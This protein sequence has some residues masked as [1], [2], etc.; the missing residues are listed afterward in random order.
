MDCRKRYNSV[1]VVS[2]RQILPWPASDFDRWRAITG[3]KVVGAHYDSVYD[4]PA[5]NDNGSG[6]A[7]LLAIAEL[8][9]QKKCRRTLRFVAFTNEE[10][11]FFLTNDMGSRRYAERCKERSEKIVSMLCLE[12]LGY[13]SDK[14]NSQK[15]PHPL[16]KLVCPTTGNFVA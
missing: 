14:P 2:S 4:C 16:F 7:A 5:A 10:S 8:F 12:T 3:C 9:S 13:Y 11:P 6:V 15:L 1:H